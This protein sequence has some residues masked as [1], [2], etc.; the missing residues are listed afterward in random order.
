MQPNTPYGISDQTWI[1]L[2]NKNY[3][4]IMIGWI[5]LIILFHIFYYTMMDKQQIIYDQADHFEPTPLRGE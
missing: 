5:N 4:E 2:G 3:Y 1:R